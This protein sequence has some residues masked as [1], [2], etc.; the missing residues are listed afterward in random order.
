MLHFFVPTIDAPSDDSPAWYVSFHNSF[1]MSQLVGAA[2]LSLME[3]YSQTVYLQEQ[4][5][6]NPDHLMSRGAITGDLATGFSVDRE[7]VKSL[8]IESFFG[9]DRRSIQA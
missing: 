1:C 6:V 3:S 5:V 9:R 7:K 4:L 8:C 2:L